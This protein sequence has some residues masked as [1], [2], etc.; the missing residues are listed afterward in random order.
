[1]GDTRAR[2]EAART[3]ALAYAAHDSERDLAR[4][5]Q[6]SRDPIASHASAAAGYS[7]AQIQNIVNTR[8]PAQ[9]LLDAALARLEPA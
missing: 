3:Y 6:P 8:V 1:M 2:T 7:R 9:E 5:L 4:A